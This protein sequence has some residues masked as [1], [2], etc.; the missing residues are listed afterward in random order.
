MFAPR[1]A[2]VQDARS[3]ASL[4]RRVRLFGRKQGTEKPPPA[5]V[6]TD[7]RRRILELTPD[8]GDGAL[9]EGPI[10]ALL[11]ETGYRE[12][13]AT[14]VAVADGTTSLYF[15]NGGGFIGA[16][17]HATVAE[18]S[19]RWLE[20]GREFLPQLPPVTDTSL[21]AE[22]RTQFLAVTRDG[23]RGSVAAEDDLG[24][25]RHDLSALFHAGHE[26]ITQIRLTQGG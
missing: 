14:L 25:G 10:L 18:A 1:S 12:A 15:S 26:V 23:P 7:L 2:V 11:M 22:G 24:E 13:V 20:T 3:F 19:V 5:D 4:A 9:G 6:Y 8:F 21:P 17:T 16:G